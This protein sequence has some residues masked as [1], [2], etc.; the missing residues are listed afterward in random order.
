MGTILRIIMWLLKPSN[1][2]LNNANS[3]LTRFTIRVYRSLLSQLQKSYLHYAISDTVLLADGRIKIVHEFRDLEFESELKRNGIDIQSHMLTTTIPL[4][5]T[6]S[7]R[8][9]SFNYFRFK[10]LLSI[11]VDDK[12]LFIK[13]DSAISIDGTVFA[14]VKKSS[15]SDVICRSIID[16]KTSQWQS[17]TSS[18]AD[19]NSAERREHTSNE[20]NQ[21][22][23]TI[24]KKS[25]KL[26]RSNLFGEDTIFVHSSKFQEAPVNTQKTDPVVI[27]KYG[28]EIDATF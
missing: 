14:D 8:S 20:S 23:G 16:L 11:Y 21:K 19:T 9:A 18:S 3:W 26:Q 2:R 7:K 25:N 12:E 15:F 1:E 27:E 13:H 4:Y 28:F 5:A 22:S 6:K 17:Y 10:N 24:E